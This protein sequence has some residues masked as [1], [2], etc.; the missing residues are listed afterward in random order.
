[1]IPELGQVALV[2]ALGMAFIQGILPL[3]GAQ[4]GYRGWVAIARPA[5]RGQTFFLLVG[6]VALLYSFLTNDFSVK[7]VATNSNT[8]LPTIYKVSAVWG[9]H[10]GSL[11]LWAFT[12]SIWSFLITFF[13]R[14]MPD[15]VVARVIGVMGLISVGFLLFMIL[16]SNPF[17]RVLPALAEG[18][19]LNPLLQDFGLAIHPPMLYLG[20]VGFAVPFAFAVA[21]M[22]GGKLDASWARWSRPWTNVAWMFL[23]LGIA[24]GSWW[25]YYELGWGGWWF[26]DPVEN[27]SFMPWLVG[28]ALMHSLAVTEKRGTFKAWTVLL[29]IFTFS[30]S[31]LG[32][33]LVR[34][35][36]LT[37]VHAFASD[38]ERG[39]FILAFLF[40]VVGSSLTLY[41]FRAADIRSQ[42][43]FE[44]VSRETGLLM[45]N[46]LLV[47]ACASVL[48][49]TLYPLVLD[50]LE[51]GK[52]SVGPPYFNSV[53]V[54]LMVP[55]GVLLGFGALARW[56]RDSFAD[57]LKKLSPAVV[58][59]VVGSIGLTFLMP[60]FK[61][62]SVL[63]LF[64]ALWV[65]S[66]TVIAFRQ[67]LGG[68]SPFALSRGFWGMT[69]GHI[70]IAVFTVG[71]T[72]TSL[73]SV[74]K[75]VSLKA[76]DHYELAGFDFHLKE[77]Q[78]VRGP[79]YQ[80]HRGVIEVIDAEGQR[81]SQ[82]YAEKRNYF[83]SSMPMTEAGIDAGLTRDLFVALGEPLGGDAWAVRLYHKPFIRWIW[84][85]AI[86]MSLG[87]LLGATDR[88]YFAMARRRSRVVKGAAEAAA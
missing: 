71:V 31:L 30:L 12:L 67:Q 6:F 54:P 4:F 13:S 87:G 57:L 35:G 69:L 3:I 34:S 62:L 58:I 68:R 37:S 86:I 53:F 56:K 78:P 75:D 36:V 70:G 65:I 81:E 22:L 26:W 88:R 39:V 48:L 52:I 42:T 9:G 61:W 76:G 7:Y 63:G 82:L 49:G 25:A 27:A 40:A 33:F 79:N 23:T 77:I 59:S 14:S 55:L 16:T 11:L 17:D 15:L 45:N 50:S 8:L 5:A 46:I 32:T 85:G 18:R 83:S 60:Q 1:M 28:T 72:L 2:L 41:A 44:L 24:L 84:L 38:P 19:D 64:I 10:E 47:V 66:A 80:G 74:E 51:L 21:A 43:K 29:A 20:Y 73:Y